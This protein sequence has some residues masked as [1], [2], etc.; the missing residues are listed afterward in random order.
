VE[1]TLLAAEKIDD[2]TAV[3]LGAMERIRAI[4]AAREVLRY[5]GK[6]HLHIEQR[7]D[8]PVGPLNRVADNQLA[9]RLLGWQP[10]VNLSMAACYHRLVLRQQKPARSC[11]NLR[12][13]TGTEVN[14]H[15]DQVLGNWTGQ[16]GRQYGRRDRQSGL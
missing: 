1:G 7:L 13:Q 9:A 6:E 3:N 16:A 5:T 10:K 4:D 8:M 12:P 14:E 2:A 15:E 11:G